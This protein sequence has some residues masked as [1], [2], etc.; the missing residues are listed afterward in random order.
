MILLLSTIKVK[1]SVAI[2]DYLVHKEIDILFKFSFLS[3]FLSCFVSGGKN[4]NF[5]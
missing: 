5:N 4:I 2:R 3:H 1:I